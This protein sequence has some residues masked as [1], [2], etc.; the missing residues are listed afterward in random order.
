MVMRTSLYKTQLRIV[1]EGF[2][3]RLFLDFLAAA[4]GWLAS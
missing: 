1:G 2:K 4:L 3:F